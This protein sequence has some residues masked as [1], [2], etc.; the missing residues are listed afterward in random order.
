MLAWLARLLPR[1]RWSASLVTPATLLRLAPGSG[2]PPLDISP[3]GDG[4]ARGLDSV[5]AEVVLRLARENPRWGYLRVVGEARKLGV[6]VSA[7]SVRRILR[8]Y[9]IGPVPRRHRGPTWAQFA[10]AQAAG[11]LACDF[12]TIETV[13]LTSQAGRA[14]S[15]LRLPAR[16]TGIR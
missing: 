2:G 8:R 7:T 1:A 14:Q 10:R 9:G 5:V 6:A 12:F 11:A 15:A 4:G 3:H 13:G 16:A